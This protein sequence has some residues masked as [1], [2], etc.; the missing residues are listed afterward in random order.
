M[1]FSFMT[2]YGEL[3]TII[4]RTLTKNRGCREE[5]KVMGEKESTDTKL[6]NTELCI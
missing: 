4:Y 5:E 6:C 2:D 3:Y 1:K